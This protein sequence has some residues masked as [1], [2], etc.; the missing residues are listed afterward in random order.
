M[1]R[2]RCGDCRPATAGR[3]VCAPSKL[4]GDCLNCS[5]HAPWTPA[6]PERRPHT[7]AIDGAIVTRNGERCPMWVQA[8]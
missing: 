6:N 3:A 5:R 8:R 1:T 4:T 7:V 2:R